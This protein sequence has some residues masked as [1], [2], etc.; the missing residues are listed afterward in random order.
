MIFDFFAKV[1]DV[2]GVVCTK[3]VFLNAINSDAVISLCREIAGYNGQHE[4]Q[5]ELKK[6]L[7]AWTPC[8]TFGGKGHQKANAQPSGLYMLDI[9]DIDDPHACF[10]FI[11]RIVCRGRK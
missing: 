9:D 11:L 10:E 2:K 3:E 6:G 7:P 4:K 1:D 5:S 8:A